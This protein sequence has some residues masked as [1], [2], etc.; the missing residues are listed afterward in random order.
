MKWAL[1]LEEFEVIYR[2]RTALK[3]QAVADFLVEFMHPEDLTEEYPQ[4]NLP[5]GLQPALP[6]WELHVDG[7]SNKQGSGAGIILNTPEGLQIEYALRFD[8][9]ASNN[10]AEYEALI[11][12][13]QLATSMGTE[14][15]RVY[16]DSQLI[17]NQILQQYEAREDNMI[18]YLAQARR[19]VA[20]L[21]GL[22]IAQIP[23][24]ENFQADRL[25][26]LASSSEVDLQGIRVEY[27]PEP[28]IS[29]PATMEV[30]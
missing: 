24:E 9:E 16:S 7:S 29:N 14:K 2:P 5:P 28:S 15:I 18:A 23:W 25:A 4:P 22:T 27:L 20:G 3:G 19:L 12:R 26:R 11:V 13:I 8:F 21:K 30:D 1:E 10:E 17:V 6:T